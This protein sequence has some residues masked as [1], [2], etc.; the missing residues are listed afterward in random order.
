MIGILRIIQELEVDMSEYTRGPWPIEWVDAQNG[1]QWF[2]V[3]PAK[4]WFASGWNEERQALANA[5][6]IAAAPDMLEALE[7]LMAVCSAIDDIGEEA[8]SEA[9]AAIAKAKGENYAKA[10][11]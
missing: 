4:I 3:G 6:L 8:R 10:I 9:R 7:Y 1:T 5:N 2:V 11:Y